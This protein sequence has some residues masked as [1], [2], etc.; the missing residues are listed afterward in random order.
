MSDARPRSL[1][2]IKPTGTPHIGNYLGA[3]RPALE[4]A[5]THDSFL[6]IADLHALTTLHDPKRLAEETYA[7]ACTWLALGLDTKEVVFYRQS[8]VPEVTMLAWILSC[9]TP[10]GLLLRGHSAYDELATERPVSASDVGLSE[11]AKKRAVI[12]EVLEATGA[13]SHGIVS[14]PVLM[15]AD[16]LLYDADVVPVGKD[17]KQ[18][19]EITQEIA[20]KL[21]N[22]YGGE[23]LK[24]PRTAI[25]EDV[26]TVPGLDGR[27]MS[28]SYDNAI[29]IFLE[30]KPLRKRIMQITTDSTALGAPLHHA[31]ETVFE[32]HKLFASREQSSA[33]L[34]SYES[35]RKDPTGG[36]EADNLFGWG[37]A[38]QALYEV[39][40]E[41]LR[42]PRA[43][44]QRLMN[45]RG[46]VDALLRE[47]A[48]RARSVAEGVLHR[49]TRATG[50][51]P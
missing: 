45:D 10:M 3:I 51:R 2:G 22:T 17:Q 38:K 15:A 26:M 28:K 4:L 43:E 7:V 32:L 18:H 48:E 27:K 14:Y 31:G 12:R 11:V 34:A 25:R 23:I 36:A 30:P 33:L 21:N 9:F 41:S 39:I 20:R 1:T 37:H 44:Y 16:I 24:V 13:L 5:K 19:L 42:A 35:G 29:E 49:V 47:G 6:F 8:D 50:L 40:E 46:H